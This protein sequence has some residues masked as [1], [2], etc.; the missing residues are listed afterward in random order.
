MNI[1]LALYFAGI[2]DKVA[3]TLG[4][5]SVVATILYCLAWSMYAMCLD[6]EKDEK[7]ITGLLNARK[8][9]KTWSICIILPS[10]IFFMAI[11]P[12]ETIYYMAAGAVAQDV[13]ADP[14]LQRISRKTLDAIE[15]KL[16]EVKKS[17]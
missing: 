13:I 2:A 1:T 3:T 17:K 4:W 15:S 9:I 12:K 7:K 6:M 5:I 8:S 10:T 16:D 11:P 14:Q